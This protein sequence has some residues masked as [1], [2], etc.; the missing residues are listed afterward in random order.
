MLGNTCV[1]RD[2]GT[3][4][5]RYTR[6][7]NSRESTDPDIV[8]LKE[9]HNRSCDRFRTFISEERFTSRHANIT[10]QRSLTDCGNKLFILERY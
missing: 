9:R 5:S 2:K 7:C 3:D 1:T 6:T 8:A 10:K 4:Q